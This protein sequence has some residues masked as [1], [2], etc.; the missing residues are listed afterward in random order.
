MKRSDGG[1]VD[2][3]LDTDVE[4]GSDHDSQKYARSHFGDLGGSG[5]SMGDE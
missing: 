5:M 2:D 3:P 4:Y 1:D